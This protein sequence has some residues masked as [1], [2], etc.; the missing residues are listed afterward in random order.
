MGKVI[1]L[2]EP[3]KEC[4]Y[5][6]KLFMKN[7]LHYDETAEEWTC[8]KHTGICRKCGRK[9]SQQM[10]DYNSDLCWDCSN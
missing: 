1:Q 8:K 2:Y 5:C 6:D 7:K 10:L 9:T 4:A 3:R